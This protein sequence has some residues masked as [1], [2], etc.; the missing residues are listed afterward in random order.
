M[1][2]IIIR[3]ESNELARIF[4][5]EQWTYIRLAH[6]NDCWENCFTALAHISVPGAL[7]TMRMLLVNSI[8][9]NKNKFGNSTVAACALA[10][11]PK[12]KSDDKT[13]K[14]DLVH[15]RC[16]CVC[17]CDGMGRFRV[18]PIEL[19]CYWHLNSGEARWHRRHGMR[20]QPSHNSQKTPCGRAHAEMAW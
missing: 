13:F 4:D 6:D 15:V 2:F 8:A 10:S 19:C 12:T 14:R 3:T 11:S 18:S 9:C 1:W 16:M 17:V 20:F 5:P 7:V